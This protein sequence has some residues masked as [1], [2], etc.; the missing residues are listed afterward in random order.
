MSNQKKAS[1]RCPCYTCKFRGEVPGSAHS[2]CLFGIHALPA[3]KA[4]KALSNSV[5]GITIGGEVLLE[6]DPV[7][8]E[9]GWATWPFNFD[10]VWVVQ[11]GLKKYDPEK[12]ISIATKKVHKLI[13]ENTKKYAI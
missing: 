3:D 5:K 9:G 10:P 1:G 13:E 6:I 8:I 12:A 4:G 2:K 7:G 11:C